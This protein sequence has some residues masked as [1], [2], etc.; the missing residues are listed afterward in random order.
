MF[1]MLKDIFRNLVSS[2][3]TR[4]YPYQVRESFPGAR[5]W[6]DLDP[7]NCNYCSVCQKMCPAGAIV[8]SREPK[9]VTLDPYR[10]I[11]CAYCVGLCPKHCL[12][13]HPSHRPV[14]PPVTAVH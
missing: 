11:A 7:D 3:A 10:C 13:M 5:G 9:S 8:V 12:T 1:T 4:P 6:L 2:P 14:K